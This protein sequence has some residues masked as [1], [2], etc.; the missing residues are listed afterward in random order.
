MARKIAD[1][2]GIEPDDAEGDLLVGFL[3]ALPVTDPGTPRLAAHL[4]RVARSRAVASAASRVGREGGSLPA[5]QVPVTRSGGHV[6]L[7]LADSVARHFLTRAEAEL[8]ARTRIE[9]LELPSAA[10]S[11]GFLAGEGAAARMHAE[12]KL[13]EYF[14]RADR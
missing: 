8:I 4:K 1:E 13:R 7:V 6:D 2:H 5:G 11:L 14:N 12:R 3:E 10:H 9:G